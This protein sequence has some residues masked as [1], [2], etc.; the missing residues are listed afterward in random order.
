[1]GMSKTKEN[2]MRMLEIRTFTTREGVIKRY[3][4]N[5]T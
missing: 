1:M 2:G 3:Y 5:K 4:F